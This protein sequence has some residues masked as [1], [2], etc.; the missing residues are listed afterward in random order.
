[1]VRMERG[2]SIL[3]IREYRSWNWRSTTRAARSRC[4]WRNSRSEGAL[5]SR[6]PVSAARCFRRSHHVAMRIGLLLPVCAALLV[7][8][9]E[10]SRGEPR[11]STG[12]L[13]I[14]AGSAPFSV[15]IGDV[16]GD[17]K[18]DLAVANWGSNTASILLGTGDGAFGAKVDYGTEIDPRSIAIGDVSGDGKPDLVTVGGLST[19]S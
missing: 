10:S 14:E 19:V 9:A 5:M 17:G 3:R 15:A 8:S 4:T 16:S 2:P 11:P 6:S 7:V 12:F 1:M 18:P 13:S